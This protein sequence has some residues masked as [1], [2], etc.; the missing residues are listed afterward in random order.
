M[1]WGAPEYLYMALVLNQTQ[2]PEEALFMIRYQRCSS[3]TKPGGAYRHLMSDA[4]KALLPLL[5]A[6]QSLTAYRRVVLPPEAL[7]GDA[8]MQYYDELIARYLGEEHLFW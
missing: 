8:L 6:F 3:I 5:A 4:D 7:Q 1:S 2:L